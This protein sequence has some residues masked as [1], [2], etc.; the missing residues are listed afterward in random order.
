M[1]AAVY[2][3]LLRAL[4]L[5]VGWQQLPDAAASRSSPVAS[6]P[7]AGSRCAGKTGVGWRSAGVG[8]D[9]ESSGRTGGR[10]GGTVWVPPQERY[11]ERCPRRPKKARRVANVLVPGAGLG[12]LAAEVA[13]RGYAS[14]HAN[15]LS[16]T[17]WVPVGTR[18]SV[19]EIAKVD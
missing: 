19:D 8:W 6:A 16:P 1:R 18:D 10:S 12:R 11:Q 17:S 5:Y 7:S 4:D 2:D 14:V 9:P 15:E 13:A 3:P